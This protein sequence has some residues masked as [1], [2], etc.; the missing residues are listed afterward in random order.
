MT[1]REL[2][3]FCD[4]LDEGRLDNRVILWREEE[5]IIDISAE[6]LEDDY[7]KHI[8]DDGCYTLDEAG[9]SIEEAKENDLDK[10]YEKG[11]PILFEEYPLFNNH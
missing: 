2:K 11:E 7:Y 6:I 9:I 10:V 3:Q 8:D 4:S 5:A 1:W